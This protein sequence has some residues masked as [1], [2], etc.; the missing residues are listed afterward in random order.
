MKTTITIDNH[1][2]RLFLFVTGLK[3][4]F[5]VLEHP[6]LRRYVVD[7]NFDFNTLIMFS[8]FCLSYCCPSS[9][10]II[11]VTRE[12]EEFLSLEE[13]QRVWELQ[14]Q[15]SQFQTQNL[16]QS[17]AFLRVSKNSLTV[18]AHKEQPQPSIHKKH[19]VP[20]SRI[21]DSPKPSPQLRIEDSL[22][23]QAQEEQP[24]HLRSKLSLVNLPEPSL[25]SGRDPEKDTP[26]RIS[27]A[28]RK[29]YSLKIKYRSSSSFRSS[30][31]R[32]A[33]QA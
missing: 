5:I 11:V 9:M 33:R 23:P 10:K 25:A 27:Q 7:A 17:Q 3:H 14:D 28:L 15:E 2:E 31:E 16:V 8:L 13:S 32:R 1:I 6:W 20:L 12:K 26:S 22:V 21:K 4:Y 24:Q 19:S 29:G 18:P 30:K